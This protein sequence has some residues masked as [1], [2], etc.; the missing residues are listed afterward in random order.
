MSAPFSFLW[1]K[2]VVLG[3]IELFA[4]PLPCCLFE[5]L[6]HD[7]VHTWVQTAVIASMKSTKVQLGALDVRSMHYC[8]L[9]GRPGHRA[10]HSS[11]TELWTARLGPHGRHS[12]KG[13]RIQYSR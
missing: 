7:F 13:Y 12:D 1:K 8:N 5:F 4:L 10:T 2:G 6:M 9:I 3:G 11:G